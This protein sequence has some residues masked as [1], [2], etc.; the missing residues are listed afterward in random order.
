MDH[1]PADRIDRLYDKHG[2]PRQ[3]IG[4]YTPLYRHGWARI[5]IGL[6]FLALGALVILGWTRGEPADSWPLL[7]GGWIVGLVFVL[8]GLRT[9]GMIPAHDVP[10][11]AVYPESE[12]VR[13]G[14]KRAGP[15]RGDPRDLG[16]G[17]RSPDGTVWS[18]TAPTGQVNQWG[19]PIEVTASFNR[20]GN[21]LDVQYHL[22]DIPLVDRGGGFL[23][24]SNYD[25]LP[26]GEQ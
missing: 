7:C 18:M 15:Y 19:E 12:S 20:N 9:L 17:A 2:K 4:D 8:D 25:L 14:L 11:P 10:P 23:D 6:P 13:A 3:R 5:V 21:L 16:L 26:G 1:I 22:Q 24:E